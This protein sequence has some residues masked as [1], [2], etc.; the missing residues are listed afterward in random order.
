MV[1]HQSPGESPRGEERSVNMPKH[2]LRMACIGL[3]PLVLVACGKHVPQEKQAFVGQWGADE[4]SLLI[5]QEG[6]VVYKRKVGDS[7]SKAI[8][9]P[10]EG[11]EGDNIVAGLGPLKTSFVVSVPP[12]RDGGAWKMTVDGVE[13]TRR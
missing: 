8:D 4:M 7:G 9:A 3:I 11:F 10:L 12:H 6:H 2:V 5:T 13:L 1:Y